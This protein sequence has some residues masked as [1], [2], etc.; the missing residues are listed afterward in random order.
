M[1]VQVLGELYQGVPE[2]GRPGGPCAKG[3]LQWRG[4]DGRGSRVLHGRLAQRYQLRR[5]AVQRI[6]QPPDACIA[7]AC[8]TLSP[9]SF[10]PFDCGFCWQSHLLTLEA[11]LQAALRYII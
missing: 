5:A 1:K 7:I 3:R 4:L 6:L 2:R 9:L 8:Q 11:Q 10:L